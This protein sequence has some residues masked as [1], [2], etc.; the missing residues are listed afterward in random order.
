[1]AAMGFVTQDS[2]DKNHHHEVYFADEIGIAKN[3]KTNPWMPHYVQ[4]APKPPTHSPPKHVLHQ[5]LKEAMTTLP[6]EVEDEDVDFH[7][8]AWDEV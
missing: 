8:W 3:R 2:F 6:S 7:T 1:M 5:A 4:L